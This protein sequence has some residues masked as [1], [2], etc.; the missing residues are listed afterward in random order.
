ML[1][2]AEERVRNFYSNVGWKE[3]YGVTEDARLWEDLR[4]CAREYVSKCRL[5][6]LRHIPASGA[7][8]LDMASG[9]IQYPEYLAYSKNFAKRYCV[10]LSMEA[11][12]SA[13][14][15]IG[16]RGV[17]LCGSFFDL[18]LDSDMFDCV[19]SLHTLYHIDSK[20]QEHA[21]R[22]LIRVCKPGASVVIVYSNPNCLPARLKRLLLAARIIGRANVR[23]A[24]VGS[25]NANEGLYVFHHP[26]AW[27]EQF[28]DETDVQ[29]YPWRSLGSRDQKRFIPD[30]AVGRAIFSLLYKAE[31]LFPWFFV[32]YFQYPMIVLTK[33]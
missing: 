25:A 24:T 8:I 22:K 14:A 6:V 32:R 11:L 1:N 12:E 16:E 2:D 13:K 33:K 17:Y 23:S 18:E 27:W 19:I 30:N 7:R 31:N 9:P 28:S 15:K 4:P 26:L 21:V 5:R 3:E 29:I 10:D 20:L